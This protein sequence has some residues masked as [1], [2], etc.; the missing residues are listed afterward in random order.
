[1]YVKDRSAPSTCPTAPAFFVMKS[2]YMLTHWGGNETARRVCS[3]TWRR[4]SMARGS[5]VGLAR[6]GRE[7][8]FWRHKIFPIT[9]T[10]QLDT[11][12]ALEKGEVRF[13]NCKVG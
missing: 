3:A 11:V 13:D 8:G 1:M 5:K 10:W 6:H 2:L 12:S 7:G 4:R 9:L